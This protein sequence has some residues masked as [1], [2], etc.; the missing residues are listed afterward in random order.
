MSAAEREK[1]R[2][3]GSLYA[4]VLDDVRGL[5]ADRFGA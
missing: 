2:E 3:A 4:I 5:P 1:D